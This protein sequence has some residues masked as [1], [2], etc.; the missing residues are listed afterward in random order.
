M[1]KQLHSE[2]GAEVSPVGA[3]S[4]VSAL[5]SSAGSSG[6]GSS[7]KGS[8]GKGPSG[9]ES[10]GKGTGNAFSFPMPVSPL[11][12]PLGRARRTPGGGTPGGRTP[13][14]SGSS[15]PKVSVPR[16]PSRNLIPRRH[17]QNQ[18]E[19]TFNGALA[20]SSDPIIKSDPDSPCPHQTTPSSQATPWDVPTSHRPSLSLTAPSPVVAKA[21]I[22][23]VSPRAGSSSF[24][25]TCPTTTTPK[26]SVGASSGPYLI[27]TPYHRELSRDESNGELRAPLLPTVRQRTTAALHAVLQFCAPDPEEQGGAT[28]HA[29][30][31]ERVSPVG[32]SAGWTEQL[33]VWG[34]AVA[35]LALAWL[36]S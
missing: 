28:A 15:P 26:T 29:M 23:P 4:D 8:S 19:L 3:P 35:L 33:L 12:G 25:T 14:G 7:G 2:I 17:T 20:L 5:H 1:K 24:R 16:N 32:V 9:K 11:S 22:Q 18:L 27:G 31:I 10:W 34:G 6:K 13:G 21:R 30:T 36:S